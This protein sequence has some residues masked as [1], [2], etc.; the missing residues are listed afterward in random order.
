MV[1]GDR[2]F[3]GREYTYRLDAPGVSPL[4]ARTPSSVPPLAPGTPVQLQVAAAALTLFP[5]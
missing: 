5:A 3:L 4:Y 2:Q 1:V